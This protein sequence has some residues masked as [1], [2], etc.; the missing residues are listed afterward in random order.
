MGRRN[1]RPSPYGEQ[2]GG[3]FDE[4]KSVIEF[5][6]YRSAPQGSKGKLPADDSVPLFLSERDLVEKDE[7]PPLR[8]PSFGRNRIEEEEEE[9]EDF[10]PGILRDGISS[11]IIKVGIAVVAIAAV[12]VGIFAVGNPLTLF[13]NTKASLADTA[14]N[15]ASPPTQSAN[16][17]AALQTRPALEPVKAPE[18][19]VSARTASADQLAPEIPP[20]FGTRAVPPPTQR[21]APTRDEIASAFKTARQSPPDVAAPSPAAAPAAAAPVVPAPVAAAPAP[22]APVN[23]ATIAPAPAVSA[24]PAVRRIDPDELAAL[25]K[26]AKGLMAIGDIEPARLLLKRAADTQEPSAAFLL[27]E[28]YDPAV[29]GRQDMRSITPDPARAREWYQKAA[30]YG[31]REAQQR[32]S[33][34]Q[35]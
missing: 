23:V 19:V 20:S 17:T 14:A 33:Q 6:S 27:A 21:G 35:N 2:T 30:A 10:S 31:S 28:T 16:Q 15:L 25:L 12:G 5:M 1:T 22:A 9:D 4:D 29:L 24:A 26:R 7:D 3:E 11:T 13:A 32:L 8:R 34:M 18:L